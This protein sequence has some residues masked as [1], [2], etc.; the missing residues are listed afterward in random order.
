MAEFGQ[1]DNFA[2]MAAP[3][4]PEPDVS[5][6][7][8]PAGLAAALAERYRLIRPLGEGGMAMVYLADDLRH[9]R[10]V[11]LKLL[12]PELA[13][14]I[15]P[16]RFAA[17][18]RVTATLQHPHLL[19]LFDSGEAVGQLFYVMP[20]VAGET[21]RARL[22]REGQLPLGETVRLTRALAGALA[23]A[24][25]N[26]IVHRDLKPDN[27]LLQ[28]GEP[29]IADFGI[30]LAVANAGGERL[31]QTGIAVGTPRYM[32]PEQATGERV[33]DARADL[34]ALGV[35][36]YEMLSGEAPFTGPSAQAILGRM[37]TEAPRSLRVVRPSLPPALEALTLRL[38]A[39]L[40]ADRFQ[41]AEEVV[42]AFDALG[43][44]LESGGRPLVTVRRRG[45]PVWLAAAGLL[46]VTLGA[47]VGVAGARWVGTPTV[48]DPVSTR[49][50]VTFPDSIQASPTTPW[51]GAIS[52]DGRMIVFSASR[53][54]QP[55]QL[56]LRGMDGLD[57]RPIPNTR[58]AAQPLFS[59]DGEWLA[60]EDTDAQFLE[61]VRL[62]DGTRVRIAKAGTVN[63][64]DWTPGNEIILGAEQGFRGL[65]RVDANGGRLRELTRSA[66]ADHLWPIVAPDGRT[67]AFVIYADGLENARLALTSL[68]DGE[69]TDLGIRGIRP[70]GVLEEH[71]VYV[72]S[73]G[74]VMAVPIDLEARTA[75]GAPREV[76]GPIYVP[77]AFN[78][79]A[80][81]VLG[82]GGDL[83]ELRGSAKTMLGWADGAGQFRRIS[84]QAK[85]YGFPFGQPRLS[86]DQRSVAVTVSEE[87]LTSI[88]VID[89]A[90]G[91][92]TPVTAGRG[93]GPEWMPDGRSL[94]HLALDSAGRAILYRQ[95][96]DGRSLPR[97]LFTFPDVLPDRVEPSPDGQQLLVSV[98]RNGSRD[99]VTLPVTDRP[100]TRLT[101]YLETP[102]YEGMTALSPD[103]RWL[104]LFIGDETSMGLWVRPYPGPGL[105]V[106]LWSGRVTLN[107]PLWSADGRTVHITTAGGV[108]LRFRLALNGAVRIVDQDSLPVQRPGA[109]TEAGLPFGFI[110]FALARDGRFLGLMPTSSGFEYIVTSHWKTQ[111]RRTLTSQR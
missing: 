14:A 33:I 35:M 50:V 22:A 76:Y 18:I 45:R 52:P 11:A 21:L 74:M 31:T 3:S 86:P 4:T 60:F 23:Y 67:I 106:P 56:W 69:V 30:A 6:Y 34:F 100:A 83:L 55:R 71:L 43:D 65:T 75:R 58:H 36:L 38:L 94:V 15:G 27:V 90:S 109:V 105:G 12:K 88:S 92:E 42:R 110:P 39:P 81:V 72:R 8:V 17:E 10:Q 37:L 91:V 111:L 84:R 103:G 9:G 24:H 78:G 89:V 61:K 44:G 79:N 66:S 64:A 85:D 80:D 68:E 25:A 87:G 41:R 70:L 7:P 104:A 16:A 82:K 98:L 51:P 77:T 20:F 95:S 47:A 49:F 53:P 46:G 1:R 2:A 62:A 29:V 108:I 57:L 32:A 96:L 93:W 107:P 28:G 40:P 54:G 13:A 59:P 73:D 101:P 19:P 48:R 97:P 102:R 63:G 5:A 99:V 26:G